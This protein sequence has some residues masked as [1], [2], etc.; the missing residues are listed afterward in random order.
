MK[1]IFDED[2]IKGTLKL[3]EENGLEDLISKLPPGRH[4]GAIRKIFDI[5]FGG[6]IMEKSRKSI[7]Y[8]DNFHIYF[9][10]QLDNK[11]I[12]FGEFMPLFEKSW[13][14]MQVYIENWL[15][16]GKE[17]YLI[18]NLDEIDMFG[19]RDRFEKATYTIITLVNRGIRSESILVNWINAI[20]KHEAKIKELYGG[21]YSF[22]KS[23][24]VPDENP[25]LFD[26]YAIRLLLRRYIDKP[27]DF[28]FPLDKATLQSISVQRL[29]QYIE[30]RSEFDV[31]VFNY[32]YYN[33]WYAKTENDRVLILDSANDIILKYI[34]RF[35]DEYLRFTIRSK[36][37]PHLD[38]QYTFEPFTPQ[39]FGSWDNFQSFLTERAK[40][41]PEFQVMLKFFEEFKVSNYEFFFA[42]M[43]PWIEADENGNSKLKSFKDQT[44]ENFVSE[45]ETR[46]KSK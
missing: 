4:G 1:K 24:F 46:I 22:F 12:L 33:C 41:N 26:T 15:K 45:M 11:G 14:E 29:R 3:S 37:T 23:L 31:R 40:V 10:N 43:V 9:S 19:S 7:I 34:L 20:D 42:K 35:P 28:Y 13:T 27:S 44:F 6:S 21:D 38:E 39:Y 16:D 36:F 32:F 8:S 18:A 17:G 5:L 25:F 2:I 30:S